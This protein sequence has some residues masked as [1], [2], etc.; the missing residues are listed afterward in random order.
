MR[1]K[2]GAMVDMASQERQGHSVLQA[3]ELAPREFGSI[4][5]ASSLLPR[6]Q[7]QP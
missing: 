5:T 1:G 4:S 3:D 7:L 2:R 6:A